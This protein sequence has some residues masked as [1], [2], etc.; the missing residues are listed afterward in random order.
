MDPKLEKIISWGRYL[1]WADLSKDR[2]DS[3]LAAY[4]SPDEIPNGEYFAYSSQWFAALHVVIEGWSELDLTDPA[5][6]RLLSE[7]DELK[8][9]L[10]R[11]RNGVFHFQPHLLDDR[12]SGFVKSKD[13][14]S[15]W[16]R[17]LH[18]EFVRFFSD[19]L[20]GLSSNPQ[21]AEEIKST[22]KGT[23]GWIPQDTFTD[24]IRGLQALVEESETLLA[25]SSAENTATTDF[26]DATEKVKTQ[27]IESISG[28]QQFLER[29]L[30]EMKG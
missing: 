26:R 2:F 1:Y 9:L 3:L 18:D 5:I 25:A 11:Y 8:S 24:K 30:S 14:W 10:R 15:L 29:Q 21:D 20:A 23:I 27:I 13:N 22:I 6:N 16:T 19:W 4:S 7:F 12:F 28:Y 17:I